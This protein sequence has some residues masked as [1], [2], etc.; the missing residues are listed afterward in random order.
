MYDFIPN[1]VKSNGI[2]EMI[3]FSIITLNNLSDTPE[4][5]PIIDQNTA[6]FG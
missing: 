4:H 1:N 2:L 6:I 5:I 3:R